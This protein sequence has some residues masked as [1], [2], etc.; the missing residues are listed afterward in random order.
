MRVENAA[1]VEASGILDKAGQALL[2][3]NRVHAACRERPFD[4]LPD[5]PAEPR[6]LPRD[7]GF[8]LP[9]HPPDLGKRP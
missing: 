5:M 8:V 6:K 2:H 4:L 3:F 1:E 9:K 7:G